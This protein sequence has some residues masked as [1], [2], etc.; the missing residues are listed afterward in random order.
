MEKWNEMREQAAKL[1]KE[2]KSLRKKADLLYREAQKLEN[3]MVAKTLKVGQQVTLRSIP[4]SW[5]FTRSG[6]DEL[7]LLT[8]EKLG[9]VNATVSLSEGGVFPFPRRSYRLLQVAR[10]ELKPSGGGE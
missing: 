2:A 3:E 8:V 5:L 10:T 7:A 6:I 1:D 9:R 4:L